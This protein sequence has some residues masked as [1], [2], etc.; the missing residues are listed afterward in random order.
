MTT[1]TFTDTNM[2]SY[3]IQF[4]QYFEKDGRIY[5]ANSIHELALRE[6]FEFVG[7][8][9]VNKIPYIVYEAKCLVDLS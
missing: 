9:S 1:R 5:H 3:F 6:V 4:Y 8:C 7:Y 2:K